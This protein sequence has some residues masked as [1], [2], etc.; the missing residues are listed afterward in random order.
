MR[1]LTPPGIITTEQH[2]WNG[3]PSEIGLVALAGSA[4]S[5]Q[6][7]RL[8]LEGLPRGFPV[9]VLVCQHR[10]RRDSEQDV[11]VQ[12][13]G[14]S[15]SFPVIK[16]CADSPL[17]A[18]IAYVA[19]ADRHLLVS[20]GRIAISDDPA[21]HYNRPSVDILFQSLALEFGKRLIVVVLSGRLTDGAMG[22][23]IVKANGG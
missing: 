6:G 15:C 13:L 3:Y 11:L 9:P 12:I 5:L 22:V 20:S 7:F 10:R 4:G 19:P 21:R 1:Q 2:P 8:I 16:A 18:G 23:D 14:R 17:H